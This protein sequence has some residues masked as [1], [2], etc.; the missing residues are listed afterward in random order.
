MENTKFEFL[1]DQLRIEIRKR[2]EWDWKVATDQQAVLILY[3]KAVV[4]ELFYGK[5]TFYKFFMPK[6]STFD[7]EDTFTL[8]KAELAIINQILQ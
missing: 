8:T 7:R 5:L 3:K 6:I 4:M 2:G 1:V